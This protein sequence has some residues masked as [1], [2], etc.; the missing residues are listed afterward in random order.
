MIYKK[1]SKEERS[2]F[3]YWFW[4]WKAFNDVARENHAWKLKYL[5]HD[6]EKPF[7]K[8]FFPYKKVQA[9]HRKNNKHHLEYKNPERRDWE[10]LV[11]D[12]ECSH[13][14][15]LACPRNSMEEACYKCNNHEMSFSEW[16]SFLSAWRK[17]FIKDK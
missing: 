13:L 14:T 16:K 10:A 9:F 11:I 1:F 7:L 15:K 4:H 17:I 3:R 6:I 8:L 5:F 12:W 2:S